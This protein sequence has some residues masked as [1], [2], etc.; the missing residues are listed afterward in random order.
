MATPTL[1]EMLEKGRTR[2][3]PSALRDGAYFGT[4]TF[5]QSLKSLLQRNVIRVEDATAASDNADD[6]RLELKG[7]A[8]DRMSLGS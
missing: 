1:R 3:I 6:L 2:E 4:Q 8:R 5:N 7:I